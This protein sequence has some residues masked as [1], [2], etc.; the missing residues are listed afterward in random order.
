MEPNEAGNWP[1]DQPRNSATVT[2]R[3]VMQGLE[4]ILF[5]S[6]NSDDHGWQFIGSSAVAMTDIMLVGLVEVVKRD[7]TVFEV[8]DLAPG[9]QAYRAKAGDQWARRELPP[10][11]EDE[12]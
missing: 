2:T 6:H 5:V 9:W 1:F 4:P 8:A 11:S 12:Q 10:E 7:P 3:Q